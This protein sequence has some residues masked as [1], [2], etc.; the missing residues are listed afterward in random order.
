MDA[1]SVWKDYFARW[2]AEVPRA[3]V[4]VTNFDEQIPFDGFAVSE[5]MLLIERRN[6]D[7]MGAR[8]IL[9]TYD[10]VAAVK[11]IDVVKVKAFASLGFQEPPRSKKA[12][13]DG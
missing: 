10:A 11:I 1:A 8:K 6:P 7:T 3:G 2:P 9:L 5:Q 4:I 13:D 12:G